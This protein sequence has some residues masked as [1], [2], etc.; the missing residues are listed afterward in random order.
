MTSSRSRSR[1]GVVNTTA[2]A[3]SIMCMR[4]DLRLA[5]TGFSAGRASRRRPAASEAPEMRALAAGAA[6]ACL[7]A[8]SVACRP[9]PSE[10]ST[11]APPPPPTRRNEVREVLHGVEIVD[12]YR[13]LEDDASP[14]TRAWIDA[15]NAYTHGLLDE[16]PGR[17]AIRKRIEA[18]RAQLRQEALLEQ[19]QQN[20][21]QPPAK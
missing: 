20:P 19:Q 8:L 21:Q 17:D 16:R 12:P 3:S 13:W 2:P 18:R 6:A 1:W 15:Q 11:G 7:L 9:V 5:A 14:E 10:V 4:L